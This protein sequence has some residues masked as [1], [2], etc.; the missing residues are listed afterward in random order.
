MTTTPVACPCCGNSDPLFYTPDCVMCGDVIAPRVPRPK[1][2]CG[3]VVASFDQWRG[4]DGKL[5]C[6]PECAAMHGQPV[7]G[8]SRVCP[9]CRRPTVGFCYRE[10]C[11]EH[12]ADA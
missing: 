8:M 12:A 3:H 7:P 1:N 9:V 10:D 6:S 4:A 5:Y 2:D 11:S